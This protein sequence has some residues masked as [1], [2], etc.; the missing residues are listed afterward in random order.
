VRSSQFFDEA[1]AYLQEAFVRAE[2]R[3]QGVGQALLARAEAWCE[4][5]GAVDLRLDV[6]AANTL[7]TRFWTLA[8]FAVESMTMKKSLR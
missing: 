4:S 8:G 3:S 1:F 7:G 6:W 2:A 5:R